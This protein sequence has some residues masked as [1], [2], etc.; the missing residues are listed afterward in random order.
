VLAGRYNPVRLL[1]T[2]DAPLKIENLTKDYGHL[3]AVDDVSFDI[4]EGEIFG[5]LGP[6]GA[7]KTSIISI[8]TTLEEPTSGSAS[9]FGYDV[10]KQ[11]KEAKYL[12]GCV[13][14]E[15]VHHGFFSLEEVLAIHSGYYG[16]WN[17]Q[18]RIEYLIEKLD[19][20]RHRKK[21]VKELSGGMKRRLLIAKA[22]VHEPKLLLLDE[23]TAGV[24]IELRATLWDFCRELQKTGVSI[25][26]TTHYLEEAEA[27]CDRVLF[28]D[29][30]KLKLLGEPKQLINEL[31]ER[32][33]VMILK[34]PVPPVQHPHLI[35]QTDHQLIFRFA[36]SK[37]MGD[38]IA[39]LP[40]D[41]RGIQDFI[42][43]EGKLEHAFERIICKSHE[44]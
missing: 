38:L 28:L 1:L 34:D 16:R 36:S 11:P 4:K 39:E 2:M 12:T 6:N 3:R 22:L 37:S 21:R 5:L 40:L 24:D 27:L 41:I 43:R 7:G 30:G 29:H 10:A 18:E 35:S 20:K 19:L 23:P 31:T 8:I 26:L 15:L 17:N 44:Y 25:L 13:P 42:I 32:E 9:V 14:Q 33:V